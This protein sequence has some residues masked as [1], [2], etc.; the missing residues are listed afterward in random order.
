MLADRLARA[1]GEGSKVPVSDLRS[2]LQQWVVNPKLATVMS[3]VTPTLLSYTVAL[4]FSSYVLFQARKPDKW[5]G[6]IFT[7]AMNKGHESM[8][9]WGLGQVV[10]ESGFKAL[11]VGCG[12]GRT[13]EK[14]AA[15]ASAGMVHGID[16]AD[17]S[18]ATSREHNQHLIN[19]GLVVIQKATVSQLPFPDNSFDLV[20]AV[21][22]QYYWPDLVRDMREILRVLKP[23]GKLVVVA[24][25][26]KGGKYDK[27]K[28][29]VMWLL[30][31]SHLSVTGHR[32]LFSAAGYTGI[33]IFEEHSKG[34]ICG[35][36]EK[37]QGRES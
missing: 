25:T 17:G 31:S 14:L 21:E 16:Y 22:T 15:L 11:D 13:I 23:G 8:T 1:S 33:E 18:V 34:W 37:A 24:E 6:R 28:W 5:F 9:N 10:I 4:G 27:L 30:R 36:G 12:G 32:E 7:R 35:V 2:C 29:P 20:T 3:R 26:Y 19:A